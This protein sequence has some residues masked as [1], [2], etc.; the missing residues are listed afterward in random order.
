[1]TLVK[2]T[3]IIGVSISETIQE[4]EKE[5]ID[6]QHKTK[7]FRKEKDR[8]E[9][10]KQWRQAFIEVIGMLKS[11]EKHEYETIKK[12]FMA[13][14]NAAHAELE[15]EVLENEFEEFYKREFDRTQ[16][17]EELKKEEK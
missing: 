6:K 1:M 12:I 13:G 5:L 11:V 17:K 4:I 16:V 9:A 10:M 2:T 3:E 15:T 8:L 7:I 14:T